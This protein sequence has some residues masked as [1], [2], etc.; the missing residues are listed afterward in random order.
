M[1]LVIND[2]FGHSAVVGKGE[3]MSIDDILR[4]KRPVL[5]MNEFISGVGENES[6][7]PALDGNSLED[8]SF[9][10]PQSPLASARP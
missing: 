8:S 3:F 10:S 2:F 1:I 7:E 5:P 6:D 9:S 4:Y